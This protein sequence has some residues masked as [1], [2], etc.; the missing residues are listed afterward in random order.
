MGGGRQGFVD[1][2]HLTYV[3][4]WH[5]LREG[6]DDNALGC[7]PQSPSQLLSATAAQ[8]AT[9]NKHDPVLQQNR[10]YK[11]KLLPCGP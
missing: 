2:V 11:N 3:R 4:S 9:E 5:T 10:L 1:T 6:P 8:K 7:E